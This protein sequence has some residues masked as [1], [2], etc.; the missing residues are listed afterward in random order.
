MALSLTWGTGASAA[1]Q[2][3]T[4]N[5]AQADVPPAQ[6]LGG[7]GRGVLVAVVDTWVDP[8]D[9]QFGGR[10]VDEADCLPGSCRDHAYA[11]D[12]CV[13]GTHVA[14]TIASAGY[15]VA[16]EADI[17]AVQVL[18][19]PPGPPDPSASCSGSAS[20]VAAGID[21]AVAKGA[22]VINLSLGDAVP[23]LFQSS[24]ITDAVANAADHGVVV[25]FA[26]GN[27]G[28][29]LTDSYGQ[30]A[31]IVAATG[32]SGQL[33][34]YSNFDTPVTGAV[35]VAAPGGDTGGSGSC[36]PADC[37]LSTFPGNQLGLM[38]GTSMAAPHVSGLAALLLAQN[39]ARGVSGVFSAIE[40]TARPLA[41]AGAGLIDAYK[42]LQL[43]AASHPATP[44]GSGAAAAASPA[45]VGTASPARSS[46]GAGTVP[47]AG[48]TPERALSSVTPGADAP[49]SASGSTGGQ[50]P[51]PTGARATG[52]AAGAG[53]APSRGRLPVA[54]GRPGG[55][56]PSPAGTGWAGRHAGVLIAAC[57]LVGADLVAV[58]WV[59]RPGKALPY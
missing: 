3:A 4:W 43:E 37:V 25:V 59:R 52:A 55:P 45:P 35:N 57:L 33:A 5:F 2:P 54:A 49:G 18:S 10:V 58:A 51:S 26:A 34:G 17:L 48:T 6:P 46:A 24:A 44:T 31:L 8:G 42:A 14:G 56:E 29:P 47:K 28:V 16:P 22:K 38:E 13:H 53:P 40:D 39:P 20:T 1:A 50:E 41:G 12:S 15:G 23:G 30:D 21:F 32:P 7:Y 19:G 36:T 11:P 9:A 27:Q